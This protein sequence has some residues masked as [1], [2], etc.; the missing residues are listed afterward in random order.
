MRKSFLILIMMAIAVIAAGCS[1]TAAPAKENE[2][3]TIAMGFTP[4]VQFAPFYVAMERGYF[5]EEGINLKLDYGMETD[6]LQQLGSGKLQFAV[7]SGDQ[8]IL[9]RASGLPV[10][11][12]A[13]WYRRFPVCIVSLADSGISEP[14][15][16]AGKVVGIPALQGAS[17]IGWQAF[18][19]ES[20]INPQDVTLQ[21]IGYTQ[22]A[23]L[24][25]KRVDAVIC[26]AMNEPVQLRNDGWDINVFYLDK[27]TSLISNGLVTND[28][29]IQ[30]NPELVRSVVRA[31]LRGLQDTLQDP[32][33][34]F[35]ITRKYIP[36]MNDETAKLQRS[37]LDE[38]L[39]FWQ[40]DTPGFNDPTAW[41]ESVNLLSELGLLSA[42]LEPESVYTN[43]FIPSK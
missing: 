38:C 36:E 12:I 42:P 1:P 27:Y 24:I 22:V 5:S 40:S 28:N 13:N 11:Y 14:A 10:K 2:S 37:V 39:L 15:M 25:E 16:L 43:Q 20:G 26:Y 32:D 29:T 3:V 34:A 41:E 33:A 8:V 35:A 21:A 9:A 6:L 4:N 30:T 7:T 19:Q 18:V 23:S 17:Y 31:F